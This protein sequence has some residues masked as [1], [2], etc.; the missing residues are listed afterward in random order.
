MSKRTNVKSTCEMCGQGCGVLIHLENNRPVRVAGDPDDPVSRGAICAKGAASLEY[1][2]HPLRLRY[3][4]QR[5]GG[6]GEGKWRRI[7]WEEALDT[8]ASQLTRIKEE[9]GA[10]SL[11]FIRGGARGYQ[12]SYIA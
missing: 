3:P 8:M 7:S 6:R 9:Y 11:A 1:L 2:N 10:E 12:D 5:A 4:V